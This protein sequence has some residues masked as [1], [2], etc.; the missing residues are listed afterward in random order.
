[1]PTPQKEAIV[2]EIKELI[3]N[4]DIAIMTQYVGI[5]VA[6]ATDLRKK[7]RESGTTFKVFKN[8]LSRLALRELGL[9][10]AADMMEGPT[11]WAFS[12]DPVVPAKVLKE[13]AK[14]APF[15][16]MR[17]GILNGS[18]V[19][20]AQLDALA[21]LPSREQLVA[22]VVGT[23]AMPLRNAVGVLNALP[24]NLVNALDQIRKQKEE[25]KA[26]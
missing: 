18:I 26:A 5:N 14:E 21:E 19:N 9:E 7:L 3:S 1:M 13:F 16:A 24:R 17:G 25:A 2:A 4:N 20:G 11:A 22:Q 6:Q 15:V 8:T 12:T 23:I 10:A